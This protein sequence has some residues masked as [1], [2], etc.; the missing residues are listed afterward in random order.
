MSAVS[1]LFIEH[2]LLADKFNLTEEFRENR[3]I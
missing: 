1:D 2:P 3:V